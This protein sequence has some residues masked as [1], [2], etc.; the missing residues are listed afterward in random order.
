MSKNSIKKYPKVKETLLFKEMDDGAVI[1]EPSE[2]KCYSLNSTSAYIWSLCDGTNSIN[3]IINS[4]KSDFKK[5][6]L[7]PKNAVEQ[8]L[9]NFYNNNLLETE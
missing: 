7:D 2:E 6:E 4:I 3:E 9:L 5:F 1:Y 8:I